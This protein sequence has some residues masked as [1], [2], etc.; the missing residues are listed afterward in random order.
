MRQATRGAAIAVVSA[1]WLVAAGCGSGGG[2]GGGG[3]GDDFALGANVDVEAAALVNNVDRFARPAGDVDL[4]FFL[5]PVASQGNQPSCVGW[6]VGY[7][8]KTAQ[9]AL[10]MGWDLGTP[11]APNYANI[12]SPAFVYNLRSNRF[13]AGDAGDGMRISEALERMVAIGC[14]TWATMPYDADDSTT[15]P[16][17]AAFNEAKNYYGQLSRRIGVPGR[18]TLESIREMKTWLD[19]K[20]YPFVV[21]LEVHT[22]FRDYRGEDLGVLLDAHSGPNLGLHAVAVV[23]YGDGIGPGG[24]FLIVNSW[25]TNWGDGGF[26]W[27]PYSEL[28][29]IGTAAYGLVDATN[30]GPAPLSSIDG[31]ND[32]LDGA[33]VILPGETHLSTVG[34]L[35]TDPADWWAFQA[36]AGQRAIVALS[37]LT[38]DVDIELTDGAETLLAFSI[39]GS[40]DDES[41]IHT[42]PADGTYYLNVYPYDDAQSPYSLSLTLVA[43]ESND[44]PGGAAPIALDTD[45]VGSLG[46]DDVA[47]WWEVVLGPDQI[48]TV[49]LTGLS[50]DI[51]IEV[52]EEDPQAGIDPPIGSSYNADAD[53]ETITFRAG[54]SG[55]TYH[56]LTY[57]WG[58]ASS[59]YTL[60]VSTGGPEL[61][62]ATVDF[63]FT[64]FSDRVE[65]S[66]SN[67]QVTNDGAF[68]SPEFEVVHGLARTNAP[69][70]EY[71]FMTE[72]FRWYC[73]FL[74][75]GD[76]FTW[77][78]G[79][80]TIYKDGIT[81]SG[82]YYLMFQ[83]DFV[84]GN[85]SGAI[86]EANESDNYAYSGAPAIPIK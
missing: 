84:W 50:D 79:D 63:T 75:A 8:T 55:G 46:G 81:P 73:D 16:T 41:V 5:P 35:E 85:L 80:E 19:N 13:L 11:E 57:P 42:F 4:G 77:S 86:P 26:A 45:E 59:T 78:S 24:S 48:V 14:A 12:F 70:D 67:L 60:R 3:G 74:A 83:A 15:P 49:T 2:G 71:W 38:S 62:L 47:D 28:E 30:F 17:V 44:I 39:N 32:V 53:D 54:P 33:G 66:V 21:S 7:Y 34:G 56:I 72:G 29:Q 69:G 40:T 6:A 61:R 23:G 58:G 64:D 27:L 31:G 18:P 36:T 43:G 9:E 65:T 52:F 82:T 10:E 76:T 37:G 51:D 68:D 25:G 1:V 20:G 22:S